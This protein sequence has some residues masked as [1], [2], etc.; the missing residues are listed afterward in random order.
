[1]ARWYCFF[2]SQRSDW[3]DQCWFKFSLATGPLGYQALIVQY[4]WVGKFN[5]LTYRWKLNHAFFLKWLL[6]FPLDP[7]STDS[8]VKRAKQ[9]EWFFLT[10]LIMKY[11]TSCYWSRRCFYTCPSFEK[12]FQHFLIR[13]KQSGT[14]INTHSQ[15]FF[16]SI[17]DGF[18]LRLLANHP[19]LCFRKKWRSFQLWRLAK[20][21]FC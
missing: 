12:F 2:I 19:Y 21:Y 14:Y 11:F 13:L 16:R 6:L 8:T 18:V 10:I 20:C 3:I 7:F 17:Q 4:F 9:P 15:V 5:I 1:M